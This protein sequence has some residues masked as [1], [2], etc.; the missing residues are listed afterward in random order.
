MA[1]VPSAGALA[2]LAHQAG[3]RSG[4]ALPVARPVVTVGRAGGCDVVIDDDSV[5]ARHA[6]LEFEG[7]AWRI[8]DLGST[9]GTAIGGAKL[10]PNVPAPLPYGSL[11]RFGGV[12]LEFQEAKGAD[13][14]AARAAYVPPPPPKTLKEER[15]GFRLPVWLVLLVLV[16]L[17]VVAFV[18]LELG[19]APTPG[20]LPAP[21]AP[22]APSAQGPAPAA[23]S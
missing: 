19:Q 18:V 22:D 8:T 23:A 21:V 20:Q 5:S 10:A 7:G 3:P 11:V 4:E 12:K 2:T 14:E 6:R 1:Q 17:A 9:N 16:I 15:S 13:V